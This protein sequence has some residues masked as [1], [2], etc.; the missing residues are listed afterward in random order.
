MHPDECLVMQ[1]A[2]SNTAVTVQLKNYKQYEEVT[3][4]AGRPVWRLKYKVL[5]L[6]AMSLSTKLPRCLRVNYRMCSKLPLFLPSLSKVQ[7]LLTGCVFRDT[8]KVGS[9][10]GLMSNS[11]PFL[12]NAS[13]LS[14][15][16]SSLEDERFS[17]FGLQH[18]AMHCG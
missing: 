14:I 4:I 16:N 9:A 13:M 12:W 11:N 18:T 3:F 2:N 10:S 1:L 7:F 15:S 17:G 6:I 8:L 5:W